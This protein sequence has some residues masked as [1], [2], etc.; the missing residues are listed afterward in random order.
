MRSS[1][2]LCLQVQLPPSLC[3]GVSLGCWDGSPV[4]LQRLRDAGFNG[5]IVK[6]I[7]RGNIGAGARVKS[8][9][10]AAQMVTRATKNAKASGNTKIWGGAGGGG[11]VSE[12]TGADPDME[13][14]FN[15]G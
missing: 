14:Y 3:D 8:P 1:L 15:R 11:F 5:V 4:E 9:S 6:D 10:I 12:A 2:A 13:T 7:C